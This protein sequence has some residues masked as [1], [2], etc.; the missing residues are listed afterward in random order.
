[1]YGLPPDLDLSFWSGTTLVQVCI[2]QND[3]QL[4]FSMPAVRLSAQTSY[5]VTTSTGSSVSEN[6][7]RGASHLIELLGMTVTRALDNGQ[8]TLRIEFG[9]SIALE[10][11]DEDPNH[12]CY[13][14]EHDG[15]LIVV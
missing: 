3:V 13:Q 11:F 10:V 2:G 4:N 9:A 6:S 15:Q 8:G 14:V 5:R 7:P 1:V 12:E